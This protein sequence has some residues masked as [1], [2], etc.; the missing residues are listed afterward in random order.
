MSDIY[1]MSIADVI[2]SG[3]DWYYFAIS[4]WRLRFIDERNNPFR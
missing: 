1:K 4:D 2:A 3:Y